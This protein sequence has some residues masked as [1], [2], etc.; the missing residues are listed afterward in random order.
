MDQKRKKCPVLSGK[1]DIFESSYLY[2]NVLEQAGGDRGIGWPVVFW[3]KLAFGGHFLINETAGF[4][5]Q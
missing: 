5:K 4:S 2:V 1:S 3:I